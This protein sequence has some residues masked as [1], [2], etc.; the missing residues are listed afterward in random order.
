MSKKLLLIVCSINLFIAASF[1]AKNIEIGYSELSSDLHNIIPMCM[2]LDNPDLFKNDLYLSD[3]TNFKY[4]T[5]FFIET[6]RFFGALAQGDYLKGLNGLLFVVHLVYG[7]TWFFLFYLLFKRKFWIALLLSLLVRGVVWLP[8]F[9]IWGI[10]DLW[11]L[12]PRTLY[13]VLFPIPFLILFSKFKYRLILSSLLIGF[14]FNFHPITGLGGTL[15]FMVLVVSLQIFKFQRYNRISLLLSTFGL[16]IG[17]LPFLITYFGKTDVTGSYDIELYKT[18]FNARIP[19]YFQNPIEFAAKWFT[20]KSLFFVLVLLGYFTYA[21]VKDRSQMKRA[22]ILLSISFILFVLPLCSIWIENGINSTF[23]TNIRMSFQLVRMQ[24]MCIVPVYF[25]M[26]FL[27]VSLSERYQ[28]LRKGMPYI[29]IIYLFLIVVSSSPSMKGIPFVSD[30]ITRSI[31][32]SLE[33]L[34]KPIK[35]RTTDFDKMTVYINN[36]VPIDAVFYGSYAL[37]SATKRSVQ[38]DNKGASILIEGNPEALI[39]WYTNAKRLKGMEE[40]E[41]LILLKEHGVTHILTYKKPYTSIPLLKKIGKHE[42]YKVL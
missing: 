18:A 3:V 14:L 29:S 12:M 26:G 15:V 5:P 27:L 38:L 6:V 31:Y 33:D 8:G 30:D 7:I 36:E 22:I 28:W 9:E 4:Y 32:P 35:E 39:N 2:K 1:F 25:A 21:F 11:S 40:A 19:D 20:L 34:L 13:A 17:S 37:R 24:K 41:R 23:D 16:L 42:L 10:S